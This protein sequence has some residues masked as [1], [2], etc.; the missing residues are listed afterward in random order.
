M[1][2]WRKMARGTGVSKRWG[3]VIELYRSGLSVNAVGGRLG[4]S[5]AAISR[6]LRKMIPTEIRSITDYR[7]GAYPQGKVEPTGTS[8]EWLYS[9]DHETGEFIHKTS[10]GPRSGGVGSAAGTMM[11]NGYVMMTVGKKKVVAHRLAWAWMTGGWP[12]GEIDHINGNRADN[13]WSN[14]RE[15]SRSQQSQNG[16]IRSTNKSG[17][18]GVFYDRSRDQYVAAIE[19]SGRKWRK[20]FN[21]LDEAI[22]VRKRVER[23]W[24]GEFSPQPHRVM[25]APSCP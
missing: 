8:L 20:R 10:R 11:S 16:K 22:V 5:G 23:E 4:C 2:V 18:L 25:R 6:I 19:M 24:F 9:Y 1:G 14:L 17:R 15:A 21:T 12:S 7:R 3:E 13:R